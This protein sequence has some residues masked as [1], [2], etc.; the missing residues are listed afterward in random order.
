VA[1]TPTTADAL[2]KEFYIGP[3]RDQLNNTNWWLQQIENSSRQVEGRRVVLAPKVRR[4]GGVGARGVGGVIP[5]A[6]NALHVEER[7]STKRVYG[8]IEIDGGI[9]EKMK[10]DKG[11]FKRAVSS[12]MED[13]TEALKRDVN[14]QLWGTSDGKIA[15][16]TV[17]TTGQT[18]VLLADATSIVQL[19]QLEEGMPVDIG[20]LAESVSGSGGPT[21]DNR[22]VSIDESAKSFVVTSN[23]GSAT[24]STDF[25]FRAG[26][27]GGTTDQ[28]EFTGIQ[29]IVD[30]TG[31]LFNID[32]ST[33]GVWASTE[34]SNSGTNRQVTDEL[35]G[36]LFHTIQRKSGVAPNG[37]SHVLAASDG[38]I[39]SY[40]STMT[41][42]KRYSTTALKGGYDTLMCEAGSGSVPLQFERDCPEN[43][44]Y[45]LHKD[46]F[47]FNTESDWSWMERDGAVLSRKGS[48]TTLVDAYEA[49]IYRYAEQSVDRRNTSGK[50]LDLLTS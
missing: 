13:V 24:A 15:T 14:R 48:G 36:Q 16:C 41:S 26:A 43:S 32:P 19:G 40:A 17:S 30:S 25:V 7:V 22:I 5:T 35:I 34:L 31:S 47:T 6:G 3:A 37:S 23:L 11:S 33:Y 10:S 18:T 21:Y 8:R 39:R 49:V 28:K 27:G 50:L 4:N 29:S 46:A 42:Q 20:T 44:M 1:L 12:E 2:L 38:V 9:I 45:L